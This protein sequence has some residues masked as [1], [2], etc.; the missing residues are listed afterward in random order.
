MP[1][2]WISIGSNIDAE[3]NVRAAV[4]ALRETLGEAILSPVYRTPA[5]GFDGPP[6]LNLVAGF[7]TGLPPEEVLSTLAA[8]EDSLGRHRGA[9][10]FD[11]RTIDLDLLTYGDRVLK[12]RGQELPRDEI[13]DYAFVLRPLAEV[14]PLERHPVDGRSYDALWRAFEGNREDMEAVTLRFSKDDG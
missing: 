4:K 12:V 9:K 2:I 8:I 13:L 3:A 10:R 7:D 14:A 5:V 1:R 6:F 11:S